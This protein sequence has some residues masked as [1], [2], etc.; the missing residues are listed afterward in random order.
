VDGSVVEVFANDRTVITSRIYPTQA[1]STGIEVFAERGGVTL[2]S[3][4]V[5]EMKSAWP[6]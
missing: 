2:K 3:L 6:E 1:G 5:W 4:D